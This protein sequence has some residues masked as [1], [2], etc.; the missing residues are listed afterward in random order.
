MSC[1]RPLLLMEKRI[2]SGSRVTSR[3]ISFGSTPEPCGPTRSSPQQWTFA[4]D[5]GTV[6]NIISLP[7]FRIPSGYQLKSEGL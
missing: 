2:S 6:V 5:E 3:P 4:K 1:V 7:T